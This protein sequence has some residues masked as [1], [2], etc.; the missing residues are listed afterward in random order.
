MSTRA[1]IR[2]EGVDFAQVYK[3]WD[4]YPSA[5]LPWLAEFNRVFSRERGDDPHYKFAQLLRSSVRDGDR[6]GLDMSQ[7]TGWGVL[8]FGQEYGQ[9]FNY[10]LR[11]DGTVDVLDCYGNPYVEEVE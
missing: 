6:H 1:V 5:T 8:A 2:V 3:H 10:I 4:G 7:E 11:T 9:D